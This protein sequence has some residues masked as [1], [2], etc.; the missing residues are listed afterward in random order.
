MKGRSFLSIEDLTTQEIMEIIFLAQKMKSSSTLSPVLSGKTFALIFEKPSLRT[1][2]TFEK[3]IYNLGGSC[4]Y[5]SQQDVGLG[6]REDVKD[7]AQNLSLWVDGIIARVFFHST[8]VELK[9]FSSIPV[10]NALSDYEHPCQ[11]LADMLTIYEVFKKFTGIKLV[12][13]GDGNNVCRSLILIAHKCNL[14]IEIATPKGY[15]P[16]SKMNFSLPPGVKISNDPQ[17]VIKGA[18]I[19]YTDVW[20]SMGEESEHS[21]RLKVFKKFQINLNTIKKAS[22]NVK[23]MHCLP[24]HKGEEITEEVMNLPNSIILRQAENRLFAQQ[25]LLVKI[26]EK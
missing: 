16:H 1:R 2:V 24:A 11:A 6:K 10:I 18:D 8:L 26:Y 9:N 13:V 21:L 14:K 15:E 4:I 20:T 3:G 25:A 5:L 22:P 19:I 7:I 23:I 12:Y 17:E